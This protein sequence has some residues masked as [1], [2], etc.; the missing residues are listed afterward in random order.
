[1]KIVIGSAQFGLKY[2]V[3]KNKIN[4]KEIIKISKT[5]QKNN[6]KYFDTATSYGSSESIIGN[7]ETK[8][9]K[10]V[11]KII[12]PQK[13]ENLEEWCEK[14]ISNSLKKLKV[15]KL[16]GL[17]FHNITN[18]LV[19]KKEI[20][21]IIF[22]LKKKKLA[23]N[24]GISVYSISD[25]NRVL[26]FW[27]PDIIQFPVNVFDQRFLSKNFLRK[28][29]K[30]QIKLYARSCFLQGHLLT[31]NFKFGNNITKNTFN[32]FKNWCYL[33]NKS[34]LFCCLHFVKQIKNIDYLV[35]GFDNN[36]ELIEIINSFKKKKVKVPFKFIVKE[37]KIIDPRK[38]Q[39]N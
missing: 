17:L 24:I 31:R 28:L 12:L 14:K 39:K 8:D 38:W 34:Q 29:K 21:K 23:S 19:R 27:T 15:K 36:K 33:N 32:N 20:L 7:L 25:V 22:N 5:L 3:K 4:K 18:I 10:V 11:T 2:G 9:K 1:M 13:K 37:K 16:H 30:L 26:N 35:V 6:L